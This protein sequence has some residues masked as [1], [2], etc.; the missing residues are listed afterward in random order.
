MTECETTLTRERVLDLN[1][2]LDAQDEAEWAARPKEPP[3]K[4]ER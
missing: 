3:G 2:W 1:D 4:R